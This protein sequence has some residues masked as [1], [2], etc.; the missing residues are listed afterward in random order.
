MS[1]KTVKVSHHRCWTVLA[2][3]QSNE[4]MDLCLTFYKKL[5]LNAFDQS[6]EAV[7]HDATED[8]N[9]DDAVGELYSTRGTFE[10]GGSFAAL[11]NRVCRR[12][13]SRDHL[14]VQPTLVRVAT[15]TVCIRVGL[16]GSAEWAVT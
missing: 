10:A 5:L 8:D 1:A 9:L 12:S 2:K 3:S 14:W 13:D 6:D 7:H 15:S 16:P 4:I 11:Q